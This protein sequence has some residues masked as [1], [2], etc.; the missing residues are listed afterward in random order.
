MKNYESPDGSWDWDREQADHDQ[1]ALEAAG[2]ASAARKR[3]SRALREAGD[4]EGA[5]LACPHGA[6]YGLDGSH[7]RSVG[8]PRAGEHG[9]RCLECGS[10]VEG[11]GSAVRVLAACEEA[12]R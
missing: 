7:A 5:A 10:H 2:R 9:D 12:T 3:R 1:A 8:D 4:L 11:Y 6:R